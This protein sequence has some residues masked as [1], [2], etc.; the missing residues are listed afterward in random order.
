MKSEKN[1]VAGSNQ[2]KPVMLD[3]FCP[4]AKHPVPVVLFFHGTKGFKDWGYWP[5][6]YRYFNHAGIALVNVN[7]SHNGVTIFNPEDITDAKTYATNTISLELVDMKIAIDWV[8]ENASKWNLD[9]DALYICG[10]SRG[11]AN[12]LIYAGTDPRVKKVVAWAPVTNYLSA[13]QQFNTEEWQKKGFVITKNA[14]TNMD[15][16]VN[17]SFYEDIQNHQSDFDVITKSSMLEIPV[18]LVHGT[19]D[20]SVP[21]SNSHAIHDHCLHALFVKLQHA[22]H[23]FGS[24]HPWTSEAP[25]PHELVQLMENTIEFILD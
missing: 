7:Y 15:L 5:F 19:E 12:V 9:V 6:M 4:V 16:P 14:R 22:G 17:F 1:I 3:V 24:K 2:S 11:G 10:H 13:F 21:I 23:T 20:E 18:L 8:I 25:M